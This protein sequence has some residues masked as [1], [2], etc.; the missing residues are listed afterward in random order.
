MNENLKF[1]PRFLW[2]GAMAANQIE[3]AFQEKGK[4]LST[5]D[6]LPYGI[7]GEPVY[8]LQENVH[9]P[10]H[11]GIDFY[12]RYKEDLTLFSE[13]GFTCLRTS[14]SWSRIFP[15]GNEEEPNEEGLKFYDDLFDEMLSHKMQP[16]VTIAHFETP[17]F[18]TLEYGGWRNR[19]L[20]KFYERYA[21]VIFNRYKNKV[22]YWMT[23]NEI[24]MILHRPY[25]GGGLTLKEGENQKQ[26]K[27]Q[28][29]H[30]QLVA[31]ALAVKALH[32][33]IPE[34]KMGC[35]VAYSPSYSL[36]SK[37]EDV[38]FTYDEER[39]NLLFFGDVQS[40]GSYPKYIL[41]M[42]EKEGISIQMEEGDVDILKNHTVDF[43]GF[44]YYMSSTN[45][46]ESPSG[47]KR[48]IFG[49]FTNPYLS[50]SEWGWPVDPIGLRYTLNFLYDR[51]SKPLFIVENGLGAKDILEGDT[52]EDSYR[53]KYLNDHLVQAAK[54]INLD[55]VD[56]IGYTSWGPIDLV[57]AGTAQ[58]SKRYGYIY[59]DL[60]DEGK[61]SLKRYRKKSFYW[62]KDLIA[63]SGETL[64]DNS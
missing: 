43:I 10:S 47:E 54:A 40:K 58:M 23:F 16:V 50:Q 59:V 39:K 17:L 19:Q 27:Y 21:K 3:G 52:V 42:F 4:G 11:E 29:A 49:G 6:T 12:H 1:P 8:P 31:S 5:A 32:E 30:H 62:Y 63:S 35:M 44:S 36:T 55:G 51:Y 15:K 48:G 9:Y 13:M 14:I 24:N 28:S 37:P 57:S 20:I 7:L 34:A 2:G 41:K 38:F 60:D 61:G 26:V 22:K 53:I 18:L 56:L 45:A 64:K 25:T 33:I 46:I